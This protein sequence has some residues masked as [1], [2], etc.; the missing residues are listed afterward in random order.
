MIKSLNTKSQ[1]IGWVTLLII[2]VIRVQAQ[3]LSKIQ[4]AS[5]NAGNLGRY[6]DYP[7]SYHT[8]VPQIEIP[9]YTIKDGPITLP[10]S[11]SYHAGGL[12]VHEPSSWVGTGWSLN[13]GGMVTRS[14]NGLIDE[15]IYGSEN[16][17]YFRNHGYM[18]YFMYMPPGGS[19]LSMDWQHFA[20]GQKDGEPDIF[21]FNFG[22]YSGKFYIR[23]DHT[24]VLIPHQDIRIELDYCENPSLESCNQTYDYLKGL[25]FTTPDGVKYYFGFQNG[26][27]SSNQAVEYARPYTYQNA[28]QAAHS[29]SSWYLYKI[30]SA[31]NE[32]SV[33]LEYQK[34]FYS[35]H[36][37]SMGGAKMINDT[38]PYSTACN[39]VKN[40]IEGV[41]LKKIVFANGNVEFITGNLREDV[42]NDFGGLGDE[43][44]NS[45]YRLGEIKIS[46]SGSALCKKFVLAYGYFVDTTTGLPANWSCTGMN[47]SIDRKRLKLTSVEEIPCTGTPPTHPK[48]QFSYYDE[49]LVPRR[50]N[51]GVDHWGFYNGA[52]NTS[53]VPSLSSDN[54]VTYTSGQGANRESKWPQMR[55]GALKKITYPTGGAAEFIYSTDTLTT[56]KTVTAY[57]FNLLNTSDCYCHY[58]S[59]YSG[60]L[61]PTNWTS[62]SYTFSVTGSTRFK[63]ELLSMNGGSSTFYLINTQTGQNVKIWNS[64]SS[65]GEEFNLTSGNYGIRSQSGSGTGAGQGGRLKLYQG[66][67]YQYQEFSD[68][69]VGGLKIDRI[70]QKDR[71]GVIQMQT[72]YEYPA[73]VMLFSVP[74]YIYMFHSESIEIVM[75]HGTTSTYFDPNGCFKW[76]GK[77]A[78]L[79]STGSVVPMR[80]TQG[81]HKGYEY[82]RVRQ[83]GNGYTEYKYD[84]SG[85]PALPG[86]VSVRAVDAS[87]CSTSFD[88]Y[89]PAPLPNSFRRGALIGQKVYNESSKLLSEVVYNP[90]YQE[91]TYGSFG[92]KS[93]ALLVNPGSQSAPEYFYYPRWYT[94]KSGRKTSETVT[95]TVHGQ[96][97]SNSNVKTTVTEYGGLHNLPVRQ[98]MYKGTS[99][100][101]TPVTSTQSKYVPDLTACYSCSQY[102][103]QL[104]NELSTAYGNYQANIYGT[105]PGYSFGNLEHCQPTPNVNDCYVCAWRRYQV[106][107]NEAFKT[108]RNNLIANCSEAKEKACLNQKHSYASAVL[109]G[110]IEMNVQN[111]INM[112]LEVTTIKD[113]S[114]IS[115]LYTEFTQSQ[116]TDPDPLPYTRSGNT[117][118]T[119]IYPERT[120]SFNP[121][122][123][124]LLSSFSPVHEIN[125]EVYKYVGYNPF[126]EASYKWDQ[127]NIVEVR[128]KDGTVTSYVWWYNKALPIVKAEGISYE[129][130]KDAFDAVCPSVSDCDTQP[131]L[132]PKLQDLR[133][134][135]NYLTGLITTY[136]YDPL[137]GMKSQTDPTGLTLNY[138]YDVLGRLYQITDQDG[139]VIK[140]Y[141]YNYSN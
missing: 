117:L 19:E 90:Q 29:P 70:Q 26:L 105:C 80:T 86:D 115:S 108:Y 9:I 24:P 57:N 32:F 75:G 1:L 51:Y 69:S 89:P 85:A 11:L 36:T 47:L 83:T 28:T 41:R 33:T 99:A 49:S 130:L 101:G 72:K 50:L 122:Y 137:W 56:S 107:I 77:N 16:K 78:F 118:P 73:G 55:Y 114:V 34:E 74:E 119:K 46:G 39:L 141:S 64:S 38:D 7:V 139:N 127:G 71:N 25:K 42:G 17:S 3:D 91:D 98:S 12:K 66:A 88:D 131:E 134:S 93:Y 27:S 13:A 61:C 68:H 8:G 87:I 30:E 22:Q 45:A 100:V 63:V 20:N 95:E 6:V 129:T 37:L 82:V 18:D 103:T 58:A 124:L 43:T 135:L 23:E 97:G 5:P 132:V 2:S 81:A 104:T 102:E 123:P 136:T 31:D 84:V 59:P 62:Y 53:F 121:E 111:L 44:N 116:N 128:K 109:D 125:G 96:T 15:K 133:N 113:G 140:E 10:I 79:V 52:S 65:T 14:V 60:V 67:P 40:N 94:L 54:G 48:W 112:P 76:G 110:I 92:F 120:I 21:F 35:Y 4:I 138:S 106:E 126:A